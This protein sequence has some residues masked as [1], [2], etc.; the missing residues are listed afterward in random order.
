[1]GLIHPGRTSLNC[2]AN[3]IGRR[4][5]YGQSHGFPSGLGGSAF[6]TDLTIMIVAELVF[7][8]LNL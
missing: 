2:S 5:I 4:C 8:S 7:G 3:L 1:M 6:R